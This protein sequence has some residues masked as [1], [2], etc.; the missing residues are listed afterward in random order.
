MSGAVPVIYDIFIVRR[1]HGSDDDDDD[2]D[3]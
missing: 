1:V 3:D 2:D